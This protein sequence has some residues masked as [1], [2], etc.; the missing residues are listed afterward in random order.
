LASST[1]DFVDETLPKVQK[2][3]QYWAYHTARTGFFVAT[4]NYMANQA[5]L[6][7]FKTESNDD[8]A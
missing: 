5:G 7:L 6:E 8:D 1:K 2:D 4:G 3:P